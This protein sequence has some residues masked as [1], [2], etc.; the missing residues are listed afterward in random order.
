MYA[1]IYL[2]DN[3]VRAYPEDRALC[4]VVVSSV[5]SLIRQG[6][7]GEELEGFRVFLAEAFGNGEPVHVRA[8]PTLGRGHFAVKHLQDRIMA[9]SDFV[10]YDVGDTYCVR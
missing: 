1:L 3:T 6:S 5:V 4:D 7:L 2:V 8:R 10:L 9:R